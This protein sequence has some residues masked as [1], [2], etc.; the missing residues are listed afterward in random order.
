MLSFPILLDVSLPLSIV[1]MSFTLPVCQPLSSHLSY[2]IPPRPK[3]PPKTVYTG[4]STT[5]GFRHPLGALECIP[6]GQGGLLYGEPRD[7]WRTRGAP[8]R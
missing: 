4:F 8:V 3:N 6:G 5:L 2:Q 1:P 7:P